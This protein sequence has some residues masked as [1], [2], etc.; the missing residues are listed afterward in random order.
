M[1]HRGA[2]PS[3]A[4]EGAAHLQQKKRRRPKLLHTAASAKPSKPYH[5]YTRETWIPRPPAAEAAGGGREIR[6]FAEE[7]VD[8][9]GGSKNRLSRYSGGREETSLV[10]VGR[11]A[12][13]KTILVVSCY[14]LHA[15][16]AVQFFSG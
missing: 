9:T 11:G 10:V 1:H 3:T 2:P 5:I 8:L 15:S 14:A 7:E 12:L 16:L 13:T 6:R 4:V